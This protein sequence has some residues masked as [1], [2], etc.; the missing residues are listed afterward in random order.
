M[1]VNYDVAII[2][3]G[4][5]GAGVAQACAAAGYS[6]I[7]I[8]KTDWA[9]GT[10]SK[11]SK[12]I[13]GGL[14]Y[15][16]T[17]QISLVWQSLRERGLLLS[18]APQLVKP[19]QFFIPVYRETTRRPWQLRI[20]LSLY[21]LLTGFTKLAR[22]KSYRID[23]PQL[24]ENLNRKD[25]SAVFSYWD[26]QT[27]DRQLTQA[28]IRSA[29]ALGATTLCPATLQSATAITEGYRLNIQQLATKEEPSTLTCR[30]L[31]NAAGPWANKVLATVTE[32]PQTLA[33]ELV[34]GS[35]LI[36]QQRI[37]EHAYYLESPIDKRA[38]FVLPWHGKTMIGTTEQPFNGDPDHVTVSEQETDYL[39]NTFKHYFPETE[40][41]ICD[42]FAGLRVL[43]RGDGSPFS[44]PR[45]C[46]LFQDPNQLRLL[47][48]YGGKLTAYRHTAE[49]VIT[50]IAAQL[51][52]Q[53]AIADTK[54]IR[55]A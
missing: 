12:L 21:A 8:E 11:S 18:I 16:E 38:V 35:H 23:S 53:Q 50:K 27:D 40:V 19:L 48:L 46:I 24:A 4:I 20:G 47:T 26:A 9:A 36:F 39:L 37:T 55:L 7:I 31:V 34:K 51:G 54:K 49:Q 30:F 15:L 25:L 10:S 22:F 14:R 13:H 45:D 41:D 42:Q 6:C 3:G 1:S 44:R 28:V 32:Q 29:R 33:M 52:T 2:G 5:H 17:A 43:P